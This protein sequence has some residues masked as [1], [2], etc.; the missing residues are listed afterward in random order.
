MQFHHCSPHLS[1][2]HKA[3]LVR[4][5]Q[6]H[7]CILQAEGSPACHMMV[8]LP[9]RTT[10]TPRRSSAAKLGACTA[11]GTRYSGAEEHCGAMRYMAA[12]LSPLIRRLCQLSSCKQRSLGKVWYIAGKLDPSTALSEDLFAI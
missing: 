1:G 3:N 5:H 11:F 6:M 12:A 7:A 4:M 9:V 8:S 10:N 2:I